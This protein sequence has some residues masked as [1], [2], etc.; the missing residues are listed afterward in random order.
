MGSEI[1]QVENKTKSPAEMGLEPQQGT[2]TRSY[3]QGSQTGAV[4]H[5]G[6]ERQGT[7][8]PPSTSPGAAAHSS[9]SVLVITVIRADGWTGEAIGGAGGRV[10]GGGGRV[11][12]AF[13][14]RGGV[15]GAGG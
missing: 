3:V 13:G 15:G 8:G 7:S 6:A 11:S 10:A 4:P 9:P 5:R 14:G 1:A 12:R 2:V